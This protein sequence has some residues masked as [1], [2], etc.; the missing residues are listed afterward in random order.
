M[1]MMLTMM[2]MTTMAWWMTKQI[3]PLKLLRGPSLFKLLYPLGT[4]SLGAVQ[5]T[6]DPTQKSTVPLNAP[7]WKFDQQQS[8]RVVLSL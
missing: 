4:G 8:G 1:M 2:M 3:L 5:E 7:V 6:P